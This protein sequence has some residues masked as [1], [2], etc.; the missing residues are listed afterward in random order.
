MHKTEANFFQKLIIDHQPSFYIIEVCLSRTGSREKIETNTTT[1]GERRLGANPVWNSVGGRAPVSCPRKTR[2][3]THTVESDQR[4]DNTTTTHNTT[5]NTT[6]QNTAN[7]APLFD[8][9]ILAAGRNT[10]RKIAGKRSPHNNNDYFSI[11]RSHL[12]E[13]SSRSMKKE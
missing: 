7:R 1:Y 5:R 4:D 3:T 11:A 13:R 2:T 10:K 9:L 6:T 12:A 8:T